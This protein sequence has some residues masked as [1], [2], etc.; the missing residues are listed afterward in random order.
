MEK[1]V[2]LYETP[3]VILTAGQI[4]HIANRMLYNINKNLVVHNEQTAYLTLKMAQAYPMSEKCS[5]Q[6]AVLLALFHTIGFFRSNPLFDYNPFATDFEY[7]SND[8]KIASNY[9]FSCLYLEF[10]TPLSKDALALE[11]F[12]QD[13]DADQ[14]KFL[15]QAE[16]RSL[17]NFSARIADF[18]HKNPDKELPEDLNEIAPNKLDPECIEAF[19]KINKN[20]EISNILKTREYTELLHKFIDNIKISESAK[21]Q[22]LK[23]LVYFL[24]FK[25]TSTLKHAINTSCYALSLG[26]RM[27]LK[28]EDIDVLFTSAILHDIGKISTPERILEFPGR[29]TPE[30]MGIMRYHVNH[31]KNILSRFVP[32]NVLE[33]VYTHHEKLNGTGYPRKLTEESLNTI[34][35]ILT[36]ADIFSALNDSRSYKHEFSKEKTLGIIKDMTDKGEL[37]PTI[38]KFIFD[39]FEALQSE[40]NSLQS[41]LKVDYSSVLQHYNTFIF[42]NAV[43]LLTPQ[44]SD[45]SING[46]EIIDNS[47]NET[48]EEI[49]EI[50]ELE[51]LEEL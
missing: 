13:F 7:F 47:N 45:N 35:R 39:D 12:N 22:S 11:D 31:S 37:D 27:N 42:N 1:T 33:T 3:D 29:L 10:M 43:D 16:Y 14:K 49:E 6:N 4:V 20:N 24:D 26:H 32:D 19:K 30:D 21:K 9:M 28:K 38:T 34:Q 51:E 5:V 25:S 8:K 41:L 17:I 36:V 15:Y 48:L 46:V 23:L 40:L 50:E 2:E 18:I 44:N